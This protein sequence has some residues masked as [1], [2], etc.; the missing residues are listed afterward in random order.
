M[1]QP[2]HPFHVTV[3]NHLRFDVFVVQP[4]RKSTDRVTDPREKSLT[5]VGCG[6]DKLDIYISFRGTKWVQLST[7]LC[8]LVE[9][10][11]DAYLLQSILQVDHHQ[12]IGCSLSSAVIGASFS[13][14]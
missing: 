6:C 3:E 10:R 12:L 8:P 11:T 13:V 4:P 1:V 2:K 9:L 7:F 14:L 5:D